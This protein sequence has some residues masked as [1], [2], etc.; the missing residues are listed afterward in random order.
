[1]LAQ[2]RETL[3]RFECAANAGEGRLAGKGT[4]NGTDPAMGSRSFASFWWLLLFV[5]VVVFW[6]LRVIDAATFAGIRVHSVDLYIEHYPMTEYAARV[7]RAGSL[8][9]WNPFQFCG[10]P[11]LAVPHTGLFYL[12]NAVYLLFDVGTATEVSL[13][14]HLLISAT[15]MALLVRELGLGRMPALAAAVTFAWSGWV[16]YQV[17]LPAAIACQSWLPLTVLAVERSL[18]GKRWAPFGLAAA[19]ALQT[20]SGAPE[21]VLYNLYAA[22]LFSVFRLARRASSA[23][24]AG[25]ARDGS[26]LL[27]AVVVGV[28][29][30]ALQ[31]LPSFELA[32]QSARSALTLEKALGVGEYSQNTIPSGLFFAEILSAR[33]NAMVGVLGFLGLGLGF[34]VRKQRNL[35]AFAVVAALL[36]ALLVFG[37]PVFEL[38][39]ETLPGRMFRRPIK[40]LQIYTFAQALLAALALARLHEWS[41]QRGPAS[42]SQ[43]RAPL[44]ALVALLLGAVGFAVVQGTLS[45]WWL[46]AGAGLAIGVA[47]PGRAP[48]LAVVWLL[49][50][51]GLSLFYS[52]HND[53]VRPAAQPGVF[54]TSAQ[55]LDAVAR[56]AGSERVYLDGEFLPVPGLTMKQGT[57]RSMRA[58]VDYQ[59]LA[60]ERYARYFRF[61]AQQPDPRDPFAGDFHLG[62]RSRWKLMDLASTRY[63]VVARHRPLDF[64][65]ASRPAQFRDVSST[66]GPKVY[67]RSSALPRANFVAKARSFD[68]PERLLWALASADFDPGSE[69]LLELEPGQTLPSLATQPT[70]TK[71]VRAEIVVD[72]AERVVV[73]VQNQAAGFLVLS[74]A[75]YP[76]W[77]AWVDGNPAPIFRAN[78]LFRAVALPPG[79]SRIEFRFAP[80]SFRIGLGVSAAVLLGVVAA[81]LW[82]YRRSPA[83]ALRRNT[84]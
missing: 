32:A 17:N 55:Q 23:G 13:V 53:E 50:V 43:G 68:D 42:S 25:T 3:A 2:L 80:Q 84:R 63:Y 4:T 30:A 31:L 19:V 39:H 76:G 74:D 34:Q 33:G 45:P 14:L 78:Y 67:E 5:L 20:T 18:R 56:S 65:L 26:L 40:F 22:G 70:D 77:R 69:V 37:G 83:A 48:A 49:I 41:T 81:A 29:A 47:L 6:K 60:M 10:M 51:H 72:A 52:G 66:E 9:L 57:L 82:L 15:G 79:G 35:W 7:L 8:P 21:Y 27:G 46:A 61:A 64:F 11:F 75:H 38:Y 58:V 54:D 12:P 71:P 16:F 73:E 24:M 59:P 36:S 62:S 44:L 28:L 1:M